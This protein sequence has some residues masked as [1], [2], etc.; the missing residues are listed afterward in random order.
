MN[1]RRSGRVDESKVYAAVVVSHTTR[2]CSWTER[3]RFDRVLGTA[4]MEEDPGRG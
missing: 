1:K 3:E 2:S 4:E